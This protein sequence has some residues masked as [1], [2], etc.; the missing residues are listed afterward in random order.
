VTPEQEE[1][2]RRALAAAA[3]PA[4]AP[5]PPMPPE[6]V[7][8]LES[9]LDELVSPTAATETSGRATG[10][11]G[12]ARPARDELAARRRRRW[13]NVLVAA[14]AVCAIAFG[15][16]TVTTGGPDLSGGSSEEST[17]GGGDSSADRGT[18]SAP[19]ELAPSTGAAP[20]EPR[21]MAPEGPPGPPLRSSTLTEDVQSL[22][23]GGPES[24]ARVR[25]VHSGCA[26]PSV[27]RGEQLLGVRLDG[28]RASLLLG[29]PRGGTREARVYLCND[30]ATPE[31]T[32]TV[33]STPR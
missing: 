1:Q 19:E 11:P 5:D 8:R 15:A 32:T 4:D 27:R 30:P 33:R 17:S 3:R 12:E 28:R 2:V 14:A 7:A 21:S 29:A 6:V 23:D 18:A 20:G 25:Q 13:P 9:V 26:A 10:A 16:L 22:V 31:A 24:L